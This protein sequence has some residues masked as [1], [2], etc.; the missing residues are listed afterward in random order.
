VHA[1]VT[2]TG[3]VATE[4]AASFDELKLPHPSKADYADASAGHGVAFHY[5]DGDGSYSPH[6]RS[7][8]VGDTLP[9]LNDGEV[10][11]NDDDTRKCVWYD[12]EGRFYAD[13]AKA[14]PVAAVHT[15]SWHR[16]NRAPQ[17]FS[18]WGSKAETLPD[19]GFQHGEG[20]DWTLLGVVDTSKLGEGGVHASVVSG[21][22]GASLGT[23]RYLLWIAEDVG[24]GTF[25][26]EIDVDAAK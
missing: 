24:E 7:G 17:R 8:A 5:F 2:A 3:T 12:N 19:P 11:Q 22:D 21:K 26:T 9:R 4:R 13:L 25:F 14:T 20:K 1:G 6:P 18:L 15:F 10:A 16:A 23:F